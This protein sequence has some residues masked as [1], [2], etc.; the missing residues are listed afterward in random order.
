VSLNRVRRQWNAHARHDALAAILTRDADKPAWDFETFLETGRQ[1]VARL[2]LDADRLVPGLERR[3][4]LDFGCGV[5]RLTCALAEH[6]EKVVGVDISESMIEQARAVNQRPDRVSYQLNTGRDLRQLPSGHFNLICSWIVL[7]HMPPALIRGYLAELM[8]V[9]GPGGLL[10]FQLP[11]AEV[12][13]DARRRFVEAPVSPASFKRRLPLWLVHRYRRIKYYW[14]QRADTH[15]AMYGLP[16]D[17]VVSFVT[18]SGCR[19]LDIRPD[20][21]HGT[22]CAGYSYWVTR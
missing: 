3:R 9:L 19:L 20:A 6:F 13:N 12:Q 18:S 4:A 17:E 22:P 10:A 1:D 11:G 7:Q 14:Y 21:S 5:G 8:R 2:M 15:M 16:S